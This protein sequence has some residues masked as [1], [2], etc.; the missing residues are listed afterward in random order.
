MKIHLTTDDTENQHYGVWFANNIIQAANNKLAICDNP[1]DADVVV[2]IIRSDDLS[3]KLRKSGLLQ[4]HFDKVFVYDSSDTP[5]PLFPGLYCSLPVSRSNGRLH[6]GAPY[7]ASINPAIDWAEGRVVDEPRR[8]LFSFVG[9]VNCSLRRR[10]FRAASAWETRGDILVKSQNGWDVRKAVEAERVVK[11]KEYA[12]TI[13]QSRFVLCPRGIG[14]S[15]YRI[16]ESLQLSRVPV[17][18]S[19]DW[20]PP[21]GPDWSTCAIRVPERSIKELPEILESYLPQ[22]TIMATQARRTWEEW[23]APSSMFNFIS[24]SIAKV[25]SESNFHKRLRRNFLPAEV[26]FWTVKRA[27]GNRCRAAAKWGLTCFR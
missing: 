23:F 22:S 18:L 21:L 15:S 1:D 20:M 19:D 12:L 24:N 14:T 6:L 16:Y 7:L 3:T 4:R 11:Q 26:A 27:M 13:A 17:I 10:L 25:S 9:S 8:F 5:I 2:V